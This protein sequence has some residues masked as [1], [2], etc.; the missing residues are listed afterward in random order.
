MFCH[1]CGHELPENSKFCPKCGICLD[2]AK[3]SSTTAEAPISATEPAKTQ[4][5]TTPGTRSRGLTY[6]IK[7]EKY[8]A[9]TK[10]AIASCVISALST[11]VLYILY[12][13]GIWEEIHYDIVMNRWS[14]HIKF[15]TYALILDAI[16]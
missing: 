4:R 6:I 2:T 10:F 3:E 5:A 9:I 7:D 12:R 16:S 14:H 13:D 15:M 11:V 8:K 1:K